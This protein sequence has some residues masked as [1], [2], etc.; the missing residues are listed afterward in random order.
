[1]KLFEK[2]MAREDLQDICGRK[3][4]ELGEAIDH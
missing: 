3:W 4:G 2:W 1:M